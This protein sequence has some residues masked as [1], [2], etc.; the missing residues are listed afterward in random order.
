[1]SC[2]QVPII[3]TEG[4]A[5]ATPY[6]HCRRKEL[7][8]PSFSRGAAVTWVVMFAAMTSPAWPQGKTSDLTGQSLED[9]MNIQVVSV[10]K[11]EQTLSRTASAVF[12]ITQEDIRRSGAMNIPDLL[13]MAPGVDVAQINSNTWA[14]TTRGF[15]GRFANELLVLVDGRSVYTPTFGGVFWDTLDFPLEDIDRIEVIRGPGGSIWGANAVNGVINI[16]TK[17]TSETHGGLVVAGGGNTNEGFNTAQYGGEVG[18]STDYRVYTKYLNDG[19]FPGLTGQDG[20]DGWHMLQGGFRTD[21]TLSP[22]DTLMFQGNIYSD[23]EGNPTFTVPLITSPNPVNAELFTDIAGG[24]LQGVWNHTYSPRSDTSLQVSYDRYERDDQLGEGRGTLDLQF[25]HHF[26][27]GARQN[28][29]WGLTYRDSDSRS[30]GNLFISLI[31]ADLNTQL[32]GAFI[33]DE[34]AIVP[35]RVYLTAGLKLE[36]NYYTGFNLMPSARAVWTPTRTQALWAA[37]SD[38]VRSPSALDAGFRVDLGSFTEPGGTLAVLALIGNPR[39]DDESLIAYELGYR[40]TIRDRL[41]IDFAAYYND[42]RHQETTEPAA[43]F[44]E[45]TPFPPHLVLPLTFENLMH[46]ETHGFELSANWKVTNRW[47]L[48]PG[49]AFEQIYM[50]LAPTS[51]DTTSVAEKEGSSPVH[52]AQLRSRVT[53]SKGLSWDTSVYFVDRLADPSVPSYTRVD[54]QLTWQLGEKTRVSLVGQNL[55]RDHHEEFVDSTGS[56][57]S[58]LVKRSAYV[59]LSW[60]F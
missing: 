39:I 4:C 43:P 50:H 29:V 52:S 7:K 55:L 28:V 21:T 15:N 38:A 19:H 2:A 54:T 58:T 53:L 6:G 48:S 18:K 33:Q 3:L 17:K 36:H 10:S 12:V 14:I 26:A 46:G 45:N 27:W 34:I 57:R 51:Q 20:G 49:Y 60:Q 5:R 35:D 1:M 13:R 44:F 42:Y 24:F 23:R 32:F 9:L 59:K 16:I 56:A 31:P 30:D 41:S 40:R 47:T 22:K 8:K 11:T 37:I 25:K